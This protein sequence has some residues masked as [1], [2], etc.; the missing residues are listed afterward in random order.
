[1][2][3]WYIDLISGN[4]STGD[5]SSGNPYLTE[6][7]IRD[8][9]SSGDEV[10]IAKTTAHSTISGVANFTFTKG[11]KTVST[12]ADATGSLAVGDYIGKATA[13]GNGSHE[14][15]YRIGTINATTITLENPYWGTSEAV[16]E[17][18]KVNPVTYAT[19]Y[20]STYQVAYGTINLTISGGWNLSTLTRD[21]ETWIKPNL[22]RTT[23]STYWYAIT[24]PYYLAISYM[25][26]LDINSFCNGFYVPG[27]D[28]F[29]HCYL[30]TYR[31][32]VS[33]SSWTIASDTYNNVFHQS[34]ASNYLLFIP[35]DSTLD[36]TNNLIMSNTTGSGIS[37][38][39]IYDKLDYTGTVICGVNRGVDIAGRCNFPG[40]ECWYCT[41]GY[42]LSGNN[43]VLEDAI[44]Y[45][46]TNGVNLGSTGMGLE[47]RNI[48]TENC[49]YGIY[50]GSANRSLLCV[51]HTSVNDGYGYYSADTSTARNYVF[52]GC[53]Y[54]TPTNYAIY[55][56]NYGDPWFIVNCTIDAPSA[57]KFIYETTTVY[58][59]K[60]KYLVVRCTNVTN[61]MYGSYFNILEDESIYRTTAPGYTVSPN[62]IVSGNYYSQKLF[63]AFVSSEK[64]YTVSFYAKK[65]V[66]WSGTIEPLIKLDGATIK[67]ETTIS[68][69]TTDYVQYSYNVTSDLITHDG[70][71]TLEFVFNGNASDF[72]FDDFGVVEYA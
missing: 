33:Q 37:A 11:S 27:S 72:Y 31:G 18:K 65:S 2:A 21:G 19:K 64:N 14:T 5:G 1:M 7:K 57:G 60:P 51:N 47:L 29:H 39:N 44:A 20:N 15:F 55:S 38:T 28:T 26:Y 36:F 12:S 70:E 59:D 24:N 71:L 23:L 10:R 69:L 58:I 46:A 35:T 16:V 66:G 48:H 68:L 17:V 25:N 13:E 3:I 49:T 8:V 53:S 6:M 41:T 22:T 40:L 30:N 56:T 67:T 34:V 32:L 4:D 54:T 63:S 9:A 52:S 42:Y 50:Y 62:Q 45:Y 61:G 43:Y